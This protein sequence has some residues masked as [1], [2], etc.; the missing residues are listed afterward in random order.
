MEYDKPLPPPEH[1]TLI[2]HIRERSAMRPRGVAANYPV[3]RR[4]SLVKLTTK[5][6]RQRGV[7]TACASGEPT[8]PTS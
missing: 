7:C 3:C 8:P 4:C 5:A 2:Q 1:R 6:A